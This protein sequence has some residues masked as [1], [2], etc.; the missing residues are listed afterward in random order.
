MEGGSWR[1][2]E[3][4]AGTRFTV[5]EADCTHEGN[6]DVGRDRIFVAWV[7]ADGSTDLD[8]VDL[9]YCGR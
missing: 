7:N 1:L 3:L 5:T 6:R 8:H 4:Q 2:A 9:R